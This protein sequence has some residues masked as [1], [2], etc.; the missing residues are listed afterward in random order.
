[1]KNRLFILAVCLLSLV[2]VKA[3]D[4]SINFE[5]GTFNEALAKAKEADK[6]LFVDCYTS[7]CGPCKMLANHVFT[8][9]AVADYFNAN[10]ISLKMECE[11]GE[12]PEIA[13]RFSVTAYP[14][15]LFINGDG[16]LVYKTTGASAPDRFLAKI[17]DGLKPENLLSVKE[18]RY[19]D[20]ERD[21]A[22]VLDLIASYKAVKEYKKATDVSRELLKSL[23]EKEIVSKDMWDVVNFYYITNC[24]TEW[25]PFMLKH[26]EEYSELVGRDA[27]VNAIG[28]TMHPFLFGYAIMGSKATDKNFFKEQKAIVDKYSPKQAETLYAFLKLGE[29]ASFDKFD[30]YFKNITT[31]V[32]TMPQSEHY[33]FWVNAWRNIKSSLNDKQKKQF[34]ELVTADMEKSNEVMQ[35]S[36][37][38]FLEKVNNNE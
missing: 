11:T 1:M 15:L 23:D 24:N 8:N 30:K 21:R 3:Q 33:R 14:T 37:K 2:G 7:W 4:R 19:A 17:Q 20:G 5:H 25:W 16:E 27:V 38:S 10:F 9:N 6:L 12:G 31:I 22:F 26:S 29:S 28:N 36:Y 18:K 32:P 34:I 13:K 35:K